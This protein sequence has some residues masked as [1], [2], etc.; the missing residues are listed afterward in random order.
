MKKVRSIV[1]LASSITFIMGFGCNSPCDLVEKQRI[2]A[3]AGSI[4]KKEI[5]S[6]SR[7]SRV[8]LLE[9]NV[10]VKKFIY[11]NNETSGFW[12]Y[13]QVGD[14]VYKEANSM[15]ISVFRSDVK[16]DF[17]LTFPYCKQVSQ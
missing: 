4:Q 15:T 8:L 1:T 6:L 17:K 14:S 16:T 13:I 9:E 5:D 3:I 7:N 11:V 12:E 2:K 10:I